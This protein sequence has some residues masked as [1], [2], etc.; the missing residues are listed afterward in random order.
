MAAG[1]QIINDSGIVQIDENYSN[2]E[3][4]SK[5]SV[6]V[7]VGNGIKTTFTTSAPVNEVIAIG[8]TGSGWAF[9]TRNSAGN[10]TLTSF[11]TVATTV[12]LYSFGTPSQTT[13]GN[14]GL[15]IFN[16]SGQVT[17]HYSKNYMRVVDCFAVPSLASPTQTGGAG[18]KSYAAGK[19][20]AVIYSSARR[21]V[22]VNDVSKIVGVLIDA[23]RVSGVTVSP[24]TGY[25]YYVQGNFSR[26]VQF[27]NGVGGWAIVI[28]VTN[29]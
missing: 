17:F 18:A 1:L 10:W 11:M 7:G 14:S 3:F 29:L 22:L 26:G 8:E 9:V 13:T 6:G 16:G 24:C 12:T 4:F 23:V 19:S 15:Q 27:S 21:T 25:A 20:Y 28:N 5:I 2:L